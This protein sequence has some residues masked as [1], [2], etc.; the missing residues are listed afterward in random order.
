MARCVQMQGVDDN[1]AR[2][3][4]TLRAA[5]AKEERVRGEL[6]DLKGLLRM[7]GQ[8]TEALRLEIARL[9]HMLEVRSL[10]SIPFSWHAG[11]QCLPTSC[12][13]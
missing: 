4:A 10:S 8:E 2:L 11:G 6:V 12:T 3:R 7:Q 9:R 5:E 1:N 13:M